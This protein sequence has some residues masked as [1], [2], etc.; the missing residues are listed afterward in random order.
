M[1][2]DG[3]KSSKDLFTQHKRNLNHQTQKNQLELERIQNIHEQRKLE[4]KKAQ[5]EEMVE[6]RSQ[7][8]K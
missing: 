7:S 4:V 2:T 6:L 5:N 1:S 8:L 3:I